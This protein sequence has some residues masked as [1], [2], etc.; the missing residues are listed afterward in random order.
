MSREKLL[1]AHRAYMKRDRA[2]DPPIRNAEAAV[3]ESCGRE[4]NSYCGH[5]PVDPDE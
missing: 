4:G 3:C 2:N 5:D 1:K